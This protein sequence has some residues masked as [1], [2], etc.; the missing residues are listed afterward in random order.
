[1][2]KKLLFLSFFIASFAFGQR[3]E[4]GI[5]GKG[6]FNWVQ[7]NENFITSIL[8]SNNDTILLNF[9]QSKAKFS[10]S[11]PIFVRFRTK[12]GL[13]AELAFTTEKLHVDVAGTANYSDTKINGLAIQNMM[14][15]Y[16]SSGL[17]YNQFYNNYYSQYFNREKENSQ[18]L[19][20]YEEVTQFNNISLNFGYTFLR[21]KKF[22]PF[23]LLGLEWNSRTNKNHYQ[24]LKYQSPLVEDYTSIYNKMP[25]L[26]SHLVFI[27][28]GAGI[29]LHN[30][31]LGFNI[32][33]NVGAVQEFEFEDNII[34][35][36]NSSLYKNITSISLFL[37]Y[38]LFNFNVRSSTDRKKLKNE[39]LKVLG[40]FKE[41]SKLI[42]LTLGAYVP[43]FTNLNSYYDH[44][45]PTD[46][47]TLSTHPDLD[48]MSITDNV[49]ISHDRTESGLDNNGQFQTENAS[50]IIGLG[51]MKRISIFPKIGFG[52]E[53]EPVKY[54]SYETSINYQFTEFD[55]E[56]RLYK[57]GYNWESDASPFQSIQTTALRQTM[58]QFSIG[59]KINLKYDVSPDL[60]V[61]ISGGAY[62][63]FFAPGQFRFEDFGYNND[64]LFEEFSNYVLSGDQSKN[65]NG[66]YADVSSNETY[67]YQ[68][69][70]Q[71]SNSFNSILDQTMSDSKGRFWMSWMASFDLYFD[72]LR[73]SPYIEGRITDINFLY[74]DYL[75]GGISFLFYLRK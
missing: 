1:M 55:T 35:N 12:F 30:L 11:I 54:F 68:Y 66:A 2:V 15:D 38:N 41:K 70:D 17:T 16:P 19:I 48:P 59:Q 9:D 6:N 58:H 64:P 21:T 18:Q 22:R 69:Y 67:S 33:Q 10:Y 71:S 73:I 14:N 60:Y 40:D 34:F 43:V 72:R 28:I 3:F 29:E 62:F 52:V 32:R 56:A 74:R 44:T 36:N 25:R 65:F 8:D 75:S 23:G 39:N 24:S 27:N 37:K 47:H 26:N 20:S 7:G 45:N 50:T 4:L 53:I 42:K 5:G 49:L 51:R 46:T 31:Q 13:W 57:L 63:N 61:G